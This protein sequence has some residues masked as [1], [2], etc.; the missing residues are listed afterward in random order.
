[1]PLPGRSGQRCGA[2]CRAQG[3]RPVNRVLLTFVRQPAQGCG[4]QVR[5]GERP[6][7]SVVKR[8]ARYSITVGSLPLRDHAEPPNYQ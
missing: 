6:Q 2:D 5:I 4:R 8:V 3:L 7:R 1:M